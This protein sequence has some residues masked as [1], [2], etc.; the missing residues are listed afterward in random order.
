[1]QKKDDIGWMFNAAGN[2]TL[3][4]MQRYLEGSL[5]PGQVKAVEEHLDKNEFDREALDGLRKFPQ[6]RV[7]ASVGRLNRR[8]G[9]HGAERRKI[10]FWPYYGI[11]A[12]VVLIAGI[13]GILNFMD[14]G[15]PEGL[16]QAITPEKQERKAEQKAASEKD[17]VEAEARPNTYK[18]VPP[19]GEPTEP[20]N[21]TEIVTVELD[22]ATDISELSQDEAL[23]ENSGGRPVIAM[24][25]VVE[26]ELEDRPSSKGEVAEV[27]IAEEVEVKITEVETAPVLSRQAAARSE[28]ES[29]EGEVFMVVEQM[30][31]FPGGDSAFA[32]YFLRNLA[33]PEAARES[34]IQGTVYVSFIVKEDGSITN[35]EVLRGLGHG[36]DE[37]ALKLIR[38]M[39][40]WSPAMQRGKPVKV[41]MNL[42]LK[43][44]LE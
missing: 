5:G 6:A 10:S 21:V 36:I 24:E 30:P 12:S 19:E 2:L 27:V 1:M 4:A 35:A 44:S 8:I 22:V 28:D 16:S 14:G 17:S 29:V 34:G 39:P 41:Q 40:R 15:E 43:F 7:T 13:I 37:E 32:D 25:D 18:L 11:A 26:A 42:P 38:Q 31:S 20:A 33:Y 23:P 3:E 9:N